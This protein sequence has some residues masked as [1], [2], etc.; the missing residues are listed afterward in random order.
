MLIKNFVCSGKTIE[1]EK[2][3]LRIL[4][5]QQQGFGSSPIRG[6]LSFPGSPLALAGRQVSRTPFGPNFPSGGAASPVRGGMAFPRSPIAI[7]AAKKTQLEALKIQSSWSIALGELQ[8]T[9]QMFKSKDAR[10]KQSWTTALSALEDT[11]Q[12]I[13]VRSQTTSSGL[14]GQSSPIGGT[15]STPGSPAFLNRKRRNKRLE[16]IGLGVGFPMLFGGGAGSVVGGGLGGLTGSFGAQIAFSAIGQQV[17]QMVA[18]V[19]EAGKAFT[20]VGGAASFMAK[21]SLFSSDSMQFRIEKLVEEEKVTE[22]AALMTQEM[23]K[24]VGGSGLKAL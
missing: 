6:G 24:Q 7:Q 3:K 22:A 14:T 9:A 17:D 8:E 4:K 5:Q 20:S 12:I 1:L 23:A 15:A 18:S 21:K 10:I 19:L 13:K 16:S 2:S 11:A